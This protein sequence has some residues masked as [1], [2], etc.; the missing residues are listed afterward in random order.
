M[1]GNLVLP[2]LGIEVP[3]K[4]PVLPADQN[5]GKAYRRDDEQQPSDRLA[6]ES[7]GH[8]LSLLRHGLDAVR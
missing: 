7:L 8:G 2:D 3:A 1:D 6:N 5:G 4:R